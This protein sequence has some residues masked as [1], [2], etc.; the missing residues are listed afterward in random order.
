M[1]LYIWNNEENLWF[2]GKFIKSLSKILFDTLSDKIISL[3][4]SITYH[5]TNK[6]LVFK[7]KRNFAMITKTRYGVYLKLLNAN[8]TAYLFLLWLV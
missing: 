6:G 4:N 2:F 7:D 8:N 3:S 1:W 5:Y